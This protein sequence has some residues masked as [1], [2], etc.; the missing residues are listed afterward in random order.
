MTNRKVPAA[1]YALLSA[2]LFGAST[3][4]AKILVGEIPPVL[5]VAFLY[6]GAAAGILVIVGL[7]SSRDEFPAREAAMGRQDIPWLAVAV[8]AGG[9]AAP[10]LLMYCLETT[11]AATASL[12]LNF[13]AVA[14]TVIAFAVFH[15]SVGRRVWVALAI[16]TA[17]GIMLSFQPGAPFALSLG[18]AGI[19]LAC[20]L[21]GVDNNATRNVS[22][23]NPFQVALVKCSAAG[24]LALLIALATTASVPGI[25]AIIAALIL[26]FLC[27]GLSVALFVRSLR[28]LGAARTGAY[29]SA[30]PFIG[31][32]LSLVLFPGIPDL[33]LV[34]SFLLMLAGVL[35]LATEKHIH[36]HHHATIEHEHYHRHP[37]EHHGHDHAGTEGEG[38]S[39][40]HRHEPIDHEHPHTPDIHHRHER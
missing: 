25:P 37:E 28:D 40:L 24:I 19:L 8:L 17:A 38:H 18:A 5:L 6:L 13:E 7:T 15:E 23:R 10:I 34:I 39:H 9:V 36:L 3:P 20:V 26:G 32:V 1:G 11:P 33:Q 2:A 35:F 31:M 22:A 29:F 16:V 4:F 14:T 21:W 27:Y 12:L 30:A